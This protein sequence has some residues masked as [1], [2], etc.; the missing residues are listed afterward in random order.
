MADEIEEIREVVIE[1]AEAANVAAIAAEAVETANER[2]EIAEETNKA[3]VDAAI[4]D[5]REA[6]FREIEER[7]G[8]WESRTTEAQQAMNSRLEELAN[9]QTEMLETLKTSSTSPISNPPQIQVQ[10]VEE[11]G[12]QEV[13]PVKMEALPEVQEEPITPIIE[14]KPETKGVPGKRKIRLL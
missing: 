5:R 2:A 6:R 7:I 10:T 3:L 9:R 13:A 1:T 14:P 4:E 11:P 8:S 12:D